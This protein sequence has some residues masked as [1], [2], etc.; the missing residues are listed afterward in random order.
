MANFN[1]FKKYID[2]LEKKE[3]FIPLLKQFIHKSIAE[4][5][6]LEADTPK[7]GISYSEFYEKF[8]SPQCL[9]S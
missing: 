3:D 2:K 9:L 5:Y 4:Q 7:D 6:S 8:P 1:P